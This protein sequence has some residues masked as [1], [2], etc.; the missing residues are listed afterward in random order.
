MADSIGVHILD[1]RDSKAGSYEVEG[2]EA[3]NIRAYLTQCGFT[4]TN[5]ALK[6]S[7]HIF[8]TATGSEA[9]IET[10]WKEY[11]PSKVNPALT[12][13]QSMIE[14]RKV[15]PKLRDHTVTQNERDETLAVIVEM[16]LKANGAYE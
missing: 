9:D 13:M 15:L 4:V 6:A 16:A 12:F 14:L 5:V 10:A 1:I 7:G 8:V 3:L 11:E 2:V